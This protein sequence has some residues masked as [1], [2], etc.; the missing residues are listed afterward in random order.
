M[1]G[2]DYYAVLGVSRS[3]SEQDIKQAYRRLA[4]QLHPDLNPGNKAAEARFKEVNEAHEVLSDH[5]KRKR[6]DKHGDQWQHADQI[7]K[8][9]AEAAARGARYGSP[10]GQGGA[11]HE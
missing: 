4:R 11:T 10:F 1:P 2:K 5:E 3:A 7:E 9:Q 6:Y 8:A